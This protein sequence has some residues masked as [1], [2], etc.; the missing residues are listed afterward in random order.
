MRPVTVL[1]LRQPKGAELDLWSLARKIE[2]RVVELG[3][4]AATARRPPITTLK[5][6]ESYVVRWLEDQGLFVRVAFHDVAVTLA[7]N[8]V[9]VAVL[10]TPDAEQAPLAQEAPPEPEPTPEPR[11]VRLSLSA[12]REAVLDE[13]AA[14]LEDRRLGA[15]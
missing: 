1:E 2:L 6:P 14:L 3:G 8:Q 7:P 4:P 13:L 9:P 12:E 15:A 10:L 5:P 11:P